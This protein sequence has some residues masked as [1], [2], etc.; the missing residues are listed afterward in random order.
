MD[1]FAALRLSSKKV[2]YCYPIQLY[3]SGFPSSSSK[4]QPLP[5]TRN[6]NSGCWGHEM[7]WLRAGSG[8]AANPIPRRG[9][10]LCKSGNSCGS[11]GMC[12]GY[13]R[14]HGPGSAVDKGVPLSPVLPTNTEPRMTSNSGKKFG[15]KLEI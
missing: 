6:N 15:N 10:R 5:T 14:S 2:I 8:K 3:A 9:F 11:S 1:N 12:S 4:P 13:S 7:C